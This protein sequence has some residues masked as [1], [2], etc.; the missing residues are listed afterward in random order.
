MVEER[1]LSNNPECYLW[2]S[3]CVEETCGCLGFLV[4]NNKWDGKKQNKVIIVC[5]ILVNM[6]F[7]HSLKMYLR[8]IFVKNEKCN[9]NKYKL[10]IIYIK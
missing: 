1:E 6:Q 3:I 10:T 8:A 4:K 7:I 2:P 9:V 5:I